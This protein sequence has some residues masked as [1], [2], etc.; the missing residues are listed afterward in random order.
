MQLG[1]FVTVL[2]W[3]TASSTGDGDDLPRNYYGLGGIM[4]VGRTAHPT[5][6]TS[7]PLS[8]LQSKM[9]RN[10]RQSRH[11]HISP[12]AVVPVSGQRAV[13]PGDYGTVD[14]KSRRHNDHQLCLRCV[15]RTHVS[16]AVPT[17]LWR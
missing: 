7:S 10:L 6:T 8:I 9:M 5:T 11:F 13:A 14:R 12:N 3:L 17:V 15:E 2:V 16:R 1:S 4:H